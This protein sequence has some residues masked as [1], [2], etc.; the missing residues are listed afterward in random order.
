MPC[1]YHR[2]LSTEAHR[3]RDALTGPFPHQC[4]LL[5]SYAMPTSHLEDVYMLPQQSLASHVVMLACARYPIPAD[6]TSRP[7]SAPSPFLPFFP[8]SP[9]GSPKFGGKSQITLRSGDE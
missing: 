8:L 2:Q 5:F 1:T 6:R 9:H 7:A 3:K 4:S